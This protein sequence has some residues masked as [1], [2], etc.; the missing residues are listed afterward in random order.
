M[1]PPMD[2]RGF[3]AETLEITQP[4]WA[5]RPTQQIPAFP[6]AA[7]QEEYVAPPAEWGA[8][9]DVDS[10][11]VSAAATLGARVPPAP[12]AANALPNE[13]APP[14]PAPSPAPSAAAVAPAAEVPASQ[15]PPPLPHKRAPTQATL[16]AVAAPDAPPAQPPAVPAP[17]APAPASESPRTVDPAEVSVRHAA[18]ILREAERARANR[19]V[20]LAE[21]LI[22]LPRDRTTD[23]LLEKATGRGTAATPSLEV[24]A[25]RRGLATAAVLRAFPGPLLGNVFADEGASSL[26][27]R[28]L[29]PLSR[30]F[31]RLGDVAG[32]LVAAWG[33]HQARRE[34]RYVAVLLAR[35]VQHASMAEVVAARVF[36]EQ[37]RVAY[38]AAGALARMLRSSDSRQVAASGA[39]TLVKDA[40]EGT[41]TQARE[42]AIRA[43]SVV[44][45]T[46]FVAPLIEV[47]SGSDKDAAEAALRA[48]RD[49][50]Q[51]DFGTAVKKWRAWHKENGAKR[52]TE[53]LIEA[54]GHKEREQRQGAQRDLAAITGE[55]LGYYFDAPK[56]ERDA[57]TARWRAWWE[58]NRNRA[59]L[60]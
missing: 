33:A 4:A 54:L 5:S 46:G 28:D 31:A 56:A 27:L 25:A 50:T 40:L 20:D 18:E 11:A 47:L 53:W 26:E 42:A 14:A 45:D 7:H 16:Q 60:P 57:A 3:T 38:L 44:H 58:Q 2:T 55:Y 52:R 15:R 21:S 41:N 9:P 34:T 30:V 51:Q 10:A 1:P 13:A 22:R 23:E 59:E 48:L 39:L 19:L 32:A 36:D 43:A 49:I 6:R 17:A 12:P 29:T 37:P 24:L 35:E 8:V